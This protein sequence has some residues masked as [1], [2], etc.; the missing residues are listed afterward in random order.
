MGF[1]LVLRRWMD[2]LIFQSKM[3]VLV[4][5]SPTKE[6]VV[7]K[8][9]RQGDPLSPILFVFVAEALAGLVRKSLEI[10]DYCGFAVKGRVEARYLIFLGIPIGGNP[11]KLSFWVPLLNKMKNRLSGWNNHFLNLGGGQRVH[12]YLMEFL[13]GGLKDKKKIH[14]V[15]WKKVCLSFEKGGLGIKNILDFNLALLNK[16]RWRILQGNDNLWFDLLRARYG[17]ISTKVFVVASRRNFVILNPFG[18]RTLS[19]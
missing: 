10:G 17:D 19:K 11:R 14:W 8:S 16:W 15:S 7:E 3:S 13:W 4:N 1:G 2:I 18:G 5:G 6:F 12:E 9:L